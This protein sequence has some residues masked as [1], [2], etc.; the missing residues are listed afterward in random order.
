MNTEDPILDIRSKGVPRTA[1]GIRLSSVGGQGW[2]L[3]AGDLPLPACVLRQTA[4]N[5]NRLWMREFVAHTGTKLAPHGKTTMSPEIFRMQMDDGAWGLTLATM[6]QVR[7]AYCAGIRR[8]LLAN[9]IVGQQ[10]LCELFDLL[11]SD[12]GLEAFCLVDSVAG[13]ERLRAVRGAAPSRPLNVL[14]EVGYAG[15]RAGCRTM[16][17]AI[18][19]ARAVASVTHLRLCGVEGFEGL[20]QSLPPAESAPKVE[21]FLRF[22]AS[23]AQAVDR[24]G[25]F[26][27]D[28][29][30]LSAGGSAFYDL[31]SQ[32]LGSSRLSR[33]ASIVLRSG[34]YISHDAGVYERS[35]AEVRD[36]SAAAREITGRFENAL[37]VWAQVISRPE[38]QRAILG[39]GRRDFGHDGGMP[40]PL[41][42]HRSGAGTL[43]CDVPP[44][45]EIA[46]V[47]DQHAHMSMPADHPLAVGDLVALGVSHP[48]TTFDKWRLIHLVDDSYQVTGAIQ[49]Y[50]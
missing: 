1:G 31:V 40:R 30:I 12:P 34:C 45:W 50:F 18:E 47:N 41:K 36:R 2:N 4:L 39:A 17:A 33:P 16:E 10:E 21:A 7:V 27:G 37:E 38:P 8:I 48:C 25:L 46:A 11:R 13:V 44:G 9:E 43:P 42:V 22:L 14:L 3:L 6:Q 32:V 19:V 28:E 29:I 20:H 5:S 26:R 35:F 23:V 24:E 49:T 15:G